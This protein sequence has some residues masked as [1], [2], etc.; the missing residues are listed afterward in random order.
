MTWALLALGIALEVAGT[1][2][3]KLADGFSHPRAAFLMYV[4]Y[5]ISLTTLT[6]ALRRLEIGFAYAVWSGAGLVLIA[7]AGMVW[8][9]EPATLE[10]LLFIALVL[11]GLVGL[12][13]TSPSPR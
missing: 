9:R 5:G 12:H 7:T 13:L 2:C 1:L 6:F 11:A 4:L 10:R 3:M 8:F